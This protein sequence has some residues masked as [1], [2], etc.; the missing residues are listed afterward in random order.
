MNESILPPSWPRKMLRAFLNKDYREEIEGDL[1][2]LFFEELETSGKKAADSFYR[3]EVFK[4]LRI[5]LLK[6]LKYP[7]ML[8]FVPI[9][10][11]HF[12]VSFRN[13]KRFRT[14]A[15]IN[16]LGLGLGLA[17][18]ALILLYV[19]DELSFDRFHAN[20][21]RIYK[22]VT[23]SQD[24]GLETNAWPV[25]YLLRTEFPEVAEVVYARRA[26]SSFKLTHDNHKYDHDIHYA[27]QEFLKLFSFPLLTGDRDRALSAPYSIVITQ[28]IED[29]FFD[30]SAT[31]QVLTLRDTMDFVVT[32]VLADPPANSQIQFDMLIS[33]STF[34]N[35]REG[36]SYNHGWGNFDTRNYLLL[37]DGADIDALRV[38]ASEIYRAHAGDWLAEMAVDFEV[39]LEPFSDVYLHSRFY[40]GFGPTGSYDKIVTVLLIAVFAIVL[41]C[42]N[43]VNLTTARAV[44]RVREIGLRKVMGSS[45]SG[46]I[47]QQ[48]VESFLTTVL[49]FTLALGL[50]IT[51]L[52]FF[53]DVLSKNYEVSSL[54]NPE[55]IFGC[56]ILIMA[57]SLLSGFYPAMIS[58]RVALTSALAGR[59]S[60]NDK[61]LTVRKGLIITQ[62][63]VSSGL[64]LA[65]LLVLQQLNF[66]REQ[67]LGF[68]KEQILVVDATNVPAGKARQ[69]FK[70]ELHGLSGV[71]TVSFTN[72]LPGRP[73]WLGQWAYPEKVDDNHV[74]TEYMSIDE[75]YLATLGLNLIAGK[76][77][78]LSKPAELEGGLIIN[79]SC[80]RAMGWD[81][82][83]DA[84]G[85]NIVS[86]SQRPAGKVIGVVQDYHG[87]GLQ[88]E[89]WP[90]AMDYQSTN[91][92]RYF[93]IRYEASNT[94]QLTEKIETSWEAYFPS[95]NLQYFFLDQDFD[96]QYREEDRLAKVL[97]IFAILILI[98]S[99]IGLFG[100]ISFITL[101]K[102]KEVGIRKVL[103][104]S[105][106]QILYLFSKEFLVLVI[107]GNV[108]VIP[109]VWIYGNQW[110]TNFAYH[111]TINP[112]IFILALGVTTVLA[113]CTVSVQSFK[114]AVANPV[115]SLRYE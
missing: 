101:S 85:R 18:G 44:Y 35:L 60:Q 114:A 84:I 66:M 16:F 23:T 74:D 36:F 47:S 73:G 54:V 102:T 61:G 100:L 70:N 52:P 106:G 67:P 97:S 7:S 81:S 77:F 63:A 32:G 13:I 91:I 9:I 5:N 109:L 86:P 94:K 39:A 69:A 71:Q 50:I 25:G 48:L 110:L 34:E 20:K 27:S 55:F 89:I 56:I 115:R 1:E 8:S 113:V 79:E 64:V 26:P 53:N 57:I 24:G 28:S 104:A 29:K 65:T 15:A 3:K 78:E 4:L 112:A 98:I 99:S 43:Y 41:A 30:G 93:A 108:I 76:N 49:A 21:D 96:R 31:G 38:K 14:Y 33:F 45:K 95:Y 12:K 82:A 51:T 72:A 80:V 19:M 107:I 37:K 83:E 40:N 87:Q 105:V 68:D 92:S 59:D 62:F 103:G 17:V 2:E 42:I 58:S 88:N 75:Q 6:K 90:K 22:V 10:V 111:T 11:N 46:L